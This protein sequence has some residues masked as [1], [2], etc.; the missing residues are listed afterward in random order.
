VG[1]LFSIA[2]TVVKLGVILIGA[3]FLRNVSAFVLA[4]VPLP[5]TL[6]DIALAVATF[7]Y[8]VAFA[9]LVFGRSLGGMKWPALVGFS[10]VVLVL[11]AGGFAVA[12]ALFHATPSLALLLGGDL[13]FGFV[14]LLF[15]DAGLL[16][17]LDLAD[18]RMHIAAIEVHTT[19]SEARASSRMQ[20]RCVLS[21]LALAEVPLGFR[22]QYLPDKYLRLFF[23]TLASDEDLLAQRRTQLHQLLAAHLPEVTLSPCELPAVPL[24]PEIPCALVSLRGSPSTAADGFAALQPALKQSS[25]RQAAIVFQVFAAPARL[26][27]LEEWI[28]RRRVENRARSAGA[29]LGAAA[30]LAEG[31]PPSPEQAETLSKP[32]AVA[33]AQQV[34]QELRKLDA[35]DLLETQV[36][37]IVWHP[38]SYRSALAI[39]EGLA[40]H[41]ASALQATTPSSSVVHHALWGPLRQR[42]VR[43]L[44]RALPMGSATF[45]LPEEAAA[46]LGIP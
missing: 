4:F 42:Q 6:S 5:A 38:T 33:R 45:L 20:L 35:P 10:V 46:Y 37:L 44:L 17:A 18:R 31:L 23:F 30:L 11:A 40:A 34:L 36:A 22:F 3:A 27:R 2:R 26:G 21:A 14:L 39:G 7:C 16:R 8:L 9:V 1:W 25:A 19:T 41:L 24:P 43:R 15:S 29:L 12:A 32:A 28:T 13:L